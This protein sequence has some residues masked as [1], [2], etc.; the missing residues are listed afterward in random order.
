MVIDR[1]ILFPRVRLRISLLALPT[2]LL[3]LWSEDLIPFFV[4]L[5]SALVHELGHILA[6]KHLGYRIRRIDILPMGAVIVVPEGIPYFCEFII[7]LAGPAVSLLCALL[8][9]VV[10]LFAKTP[11]TLYFGLINTVLGLFNLLPIKKLD[12]GK[13]L[14]CILLHKQKNS[15]EQICSAASVCA[16]AVLVTLCV[17][18][19]V[20][21]DY[22]L[23]VILLTSALIMQI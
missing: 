22:N 10:F 7:A 14:S 20:M 9:F 4:M 12:G 23:G 3:L 11:I 18:L 17:L 1:F 19:V 21:S 13:A 6:L 2:V 5:S 16:K 8:G 15:S